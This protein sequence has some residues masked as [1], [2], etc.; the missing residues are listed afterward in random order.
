[1]AI[2]AKT[3]SKMRNPVRGAG[4]V[5]DFMEDDGGGTGLRQ[6]DA[7]ALTIEG[8]D[9]TSEETILL[10]AADQARALSSK[11]L[12]VEDDPWVNNVNTNGVVT[13]TP[14]YS[15]ARLALLVQQN[16]ILGQCIGSMEVN[17]DGTGYK[18]EPRIP[19]TKA[20]PQNPK[21]DSS[22]AAVEGFFEEVY[23]GMS[24]VTL[25]R[26]IR[27]DLETTG[28]GY[29]EVIRDNSGELSLLNYLDAKLVRL[30]K[31]GDP[32]VVDRT[33]IRGEKEVN[34]KILKRERRFCMMIGTRV[35]YF[36]EY[37]STRVL[38]CTTGK[39][40]GDPAAPGTTQDALSFDTQNVAVDPSNAATEI[41]HFTV[42]PDVMTSYGVPRWVNQIPSVLGSRKAEEFNLEF[43]NNGGVPPAMI[44]VQGG[45]ISPDSR[46]LMDSYLKA[47]AKN[48]QRMV[49][50]EIYSTSGDLTSAAGVKVS[51]ERFGTERQNDSMFEK[52]DDKCAQRIRGAFRL[53]PIFLGL[54]QDYNFATAQT[55]Y[56]VAE[57]QVFEP[58]RKEFDEIINNT[59]MREIDPAYKIVSNPQTI[60]DVA[61]Q[62]KAVA[63]AQGLITPQ[64]T[65]D[66]INRVTGTELN[67]DEQAFND[68]A[69]KEHDQQ[70][71]LQASRAMSTA[72]SGIV[73]KNELDLVSL[74]NDYSSW[75]AGGKRIT[76]ADFSVLKK[77]IAKL[78]TKT[79]KLFNGY[80]AMSMLKETSHDPE[81]TAELLGCAADCVG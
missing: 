19:D 81:G 46:A 70:L 72:S 22:K 21:K 44:F 2:S 47:Q 33:L 3:I 79:R 38:D 4:P 32:I 20:D 56:M 54:S 43:F 29:M 65:V 66:Q 61:V 16:N 71:E 48:K 41:I 9:F 13:I 67:F 30:M 26:A 59:V 42:D 14:T 49:M 25:R 80:V 60:T 55:T 18:I 73:N 10:K 11:A 12:T 17:I 76:P 69:Q 28:N 8:A 52:Y 5:L 40:A 57:A 75:M 24:F 39:W 27:R 15:P 64:E 78:D 34:V 62:L 35:R 7:R 58:E 74:A 50:F 51:V 6:L 45:S 23:P 37:G 63:L 1:M 36:K 31:L 68:A 77:Q 53:P